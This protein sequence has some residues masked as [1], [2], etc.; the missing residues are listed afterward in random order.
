MNLY[1]L[2]LLA[3]PAFA[4]PLE[5][6]QRTVEFR[7]LIRADAS[8][9]DGV[10]NFVPA[11]ENAAKV[12]DQWLPSD[13]NR[14]NAKR[15]RANYDEVNG[16]YKLAF[17]ELH[18][19]WKEARRLN[20]SCDGFGPGDAPAKASARKAAASAKRFL[21]FIDAATWDESL[22]KTMLG[23]ARANQLAAIK[24]WD[25]LVRCVDGAQKQATQ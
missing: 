23:E 22:R 2:V 7:K 24:D 20:A 10:K 25:R 19:L 9:Q 15:T 5:I 3:A 11:A 14:G 6:G 17:Q 12:Y 8:V 13:F 21:G 4:T 18:W 16:W 1:A